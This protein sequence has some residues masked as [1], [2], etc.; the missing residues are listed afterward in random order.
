MPHG[1]QSHTWFRSNATF[2]LDMKELTKKCWDNRSQFEMASISLID[3]LLKIQRLPHSQHLTCTVEQD[4]LPCLFVLLRRRPSLL[5]PSPLPLPISTGGRLRTTIHLLSLCILFCQCWIGVP[6]DCAG[7]V[8]YC[9]FPYVLFFFFL[10]LA[11]CP[12]KH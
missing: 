10:S 4:S 11:C 8:S 12:R 3:R 5:H 7:C 2:V 9:I 6:I 1:G